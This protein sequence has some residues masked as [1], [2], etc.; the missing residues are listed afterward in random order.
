MTPEASVKEKSRARTIEHFLV[1]EGI[2]MLMEDICIVW[3]SGV[4]PH[5]PVH[6]K[7]AARVVSLRVQQLV[8]PPKLG[9][10]RMVGPTVEQPN[11]GIPLVYWGKPSQLPRPWESLRPCS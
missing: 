3:G 5:R 4:S 10:R 2:K 6:L 1:R 9:T 7:L 11:L 8:Q